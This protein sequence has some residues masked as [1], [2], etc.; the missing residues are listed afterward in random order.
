VWWDPSALVLGAKAP[1]GVRRGELIVKDVPR[2]VV[3]DGRGRYDRWLLARHDAR[4]AGAV[5]SLVVETVREWMARQDPVPAPMTVDPLA[6]RI[7]HLATRDDDRRARGAGFGSLV[8]AVLAQAPFDATRQALESFSA[9]EARMLGLSGEEA[10]AAA[11]EAERVLAHELLARARVA[12]ARG[13]CRRETPV[14]RT[15]PDGMLVEGVVDLAFE[16]GGAWIVVDYKTDREIAAGG[17]ERYRR[18]VAL[19][20]SA[21]AQATGAPCGGVLLVI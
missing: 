5:P 9:I 15:L 10:A 4:A 18:Q 2:D 11:I 19:Y 13:M 17:E 8:H 21:V 16:D 14:T 7:E 1:F 3:A 20:A 12:D 6:I